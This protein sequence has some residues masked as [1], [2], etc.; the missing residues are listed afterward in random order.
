MVRI[1]YLP[2]SEDDYHRV[3]A[4]GKRVLQYILVLYSKH[5]LGQQFW[6][7]TLSGSEPQL[8]FDL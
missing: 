1:G 6:K 4:F 5:P 2:A 7:E 3:T 8:R